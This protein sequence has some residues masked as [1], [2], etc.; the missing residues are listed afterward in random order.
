MYMME[1]AKL[2]SV[3]PKKGQSD[4]DHI[5]DCLRSSAMFYSMSLI[6]LLFL[7]AFVLLAAGLLASLP[8]FFNFG[9]SIVV[10]SVALA[11]LTSPRV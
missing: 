11:V 5:Q 2:K 3:L 10:P 6:S 4:M 1:S 9:V 8:T 7:V